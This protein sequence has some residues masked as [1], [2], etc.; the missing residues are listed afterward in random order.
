MTLMEAIV[1]VAVASVGT[2]G[3]ITAIL[4]FFQ[5]RS[6]RAQAEEVQ[7][8]TLHDRAV[9]NLAQVSEGSIK[10]VLEILVEQNRECDERAEAQQTRID[11]MQERADR[12]M[13]RVVRLEAALSGAGIPLPAP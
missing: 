12:R 8:E 11:A 3:V 5:K 6:E 2:G 7:R 1:T 4:N 9:N 13:E 10:T